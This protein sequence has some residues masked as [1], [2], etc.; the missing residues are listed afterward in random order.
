[1]QEPD[2][3]ELNYGEAFHREVVGAV[4][5]AVRAARVTRVNVRIAL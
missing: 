2:P 1:M 5:G 4:P 3:D